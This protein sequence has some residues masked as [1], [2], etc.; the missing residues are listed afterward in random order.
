MERAI[1]ISLELNQKKSKT[2][3]V[4]VNIPIET[5]KQYDALRNH[6]NITGRDLLRQIIGQVYE[7]TFEGGNY[8]K[9]N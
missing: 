4:G 5:K 9:R 7:Q 8:E 2:I 1:K 3:H 6:Y